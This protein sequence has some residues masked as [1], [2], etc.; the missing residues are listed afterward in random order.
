MADRSPLLT[1][2]RALIGAAAA[3]PLLHARPSY[4]DEQVVVGTWGGDYANLLR[5]N[6]EPLLKGMAVVTDI[7]DEDPRVAK[8]YAQR[9]L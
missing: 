4:A 8:L 9:R 2:R 6:V 3:L 7:G 1:T 5:D